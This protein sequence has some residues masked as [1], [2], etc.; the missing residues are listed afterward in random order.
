MYLI[1]IIPI[2]CSFQ[3]DIIQS[4][5]GQSLD[6]LEKQLEES[7]EILSTMKDDLAGDI[8]QNIISVVLAADDNGDNV[9]S[10]AEIDEVVRNIEGL[11]GVDLPDAKL[12]QLIIGKGRSVTGE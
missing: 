11:Q 1:G 4:V 7:R 10:D 12:K 3:L 5:Q 2:V 9:L 6:E 8:L